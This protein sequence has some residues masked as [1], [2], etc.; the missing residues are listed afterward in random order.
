MT[1]RPKEARGVVEVF[2]STYCHAC[3]P[4]NFPRRNSAYIFTPICLWRHFCVTYPESKARSCFSLPRR[5]PNSNT[6]KASA[7]VATHHAT[8]MNAEYPGQRIDIA[9]T[10]CT[11]RLIESHFWVVSQVLRFCWLGSTGNMFPPTC[12]K[13]NCTGCIE[14]R[15]E[16][17]PSDMNQRNLACHSV[18]TLGGQPPCPPGSPFVALSWTLHKPGS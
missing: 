8:E 10:A 11:C 6:S 12:R 17:Q 16:L 7:V 13:L 9:G 2:E 5:Q 18:R 14:I 3:T 4:H 1:S 15:Y